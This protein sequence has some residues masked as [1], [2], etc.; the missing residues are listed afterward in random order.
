MLAL[1]RLNGRCLTVRATPG[2]GGLI[3][4]AA[5][6]TRQTLQRGQPDYWHALFDAGTGQSDAGVR[7]L[8]DLAD[9]YPLRLDGT[10]RACR[11]PHRVTQCKALPRHEFAV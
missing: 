3:D 11:S 6:R 5:P 1:H 9:E 7:A 10:L 4:L 8:W 2:N